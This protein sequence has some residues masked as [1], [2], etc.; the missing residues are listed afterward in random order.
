MFEDVFE[1]SC[2]E[3][4]PEPA[5]ASWEESEDDVRP[6]DDD[7]RPQVD[8]GR[9]ESSLSVGQFVLCH[10]SDGLYYLGKILRLKKDC[11]P[12]VTVTED[13]SAHLAAGV[14]GE[15]A[16][17][18]VCLEAGPSSAA[19]MNQILICG[20]CGIGESYWIQ[21]SMSPWFCRRCVFALAKGGALKKGPLA[22]AL[23]AMKQVLSY[24]LDALDWDSQHRTNQQQSY[25]YCGGPGE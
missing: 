15:E 14:P 16:R 12:F 10:W 3:E 18:S 1:A 4:P 20:K 24:D 6:E 5:S 19:Q 23:L 25:C 7:G 22:K 21:I 9:P 2:V 17:C 13:V 11:H 8:E